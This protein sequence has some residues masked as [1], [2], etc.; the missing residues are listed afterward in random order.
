MFPS[1]KLNCDNVPAVLSFPRMS[2]SQQRLGVAV[3]TILD[4][5]QYCVPPM[6]SWSVLVDGIPKAVSLYLEVLLAVVSVSFNAV[7]LGIPACC[8]ESVCSR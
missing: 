4:N 6:C 2:L 3:I 1:L 7:K 5:I 8:W